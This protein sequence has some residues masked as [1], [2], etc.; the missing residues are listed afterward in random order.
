MKIDKEE[1]K[2]LEMDKE[3]LGFMNGFAYACAQCLR[4]YFEGAFEQLWKESGFEVSDL[5]GCE[6]YD[7][8]EIRKY[9]KKYEKK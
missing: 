4:L 2:R 6:K 3:N 8:N 5:N 7:A 9:L 1:G